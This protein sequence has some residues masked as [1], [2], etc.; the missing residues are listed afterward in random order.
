MVK[1]QAAGAAGQPVRLRL[2]PNPPLPLRQQRLF[3]SVLGCFMG[4]YAGALAI[5][6]FWPV[7]PFAGLEFAAVAAAMWVTAGRG[8]RCEVVEVTAS[9]VRVDRSRA[10]GVASIEL[11]SAW[12]QIRLV[13]GAVRWYPSR[14]LLG[15][16]GR[17]VE[18]GGFLTENERRAAAREL[19]RVLAPY[20]AWSNAALQVGRS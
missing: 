3:L 9:R 15:A 6:G 7:L 8:R 10:L 18:I 20:S 16:H 1:V 12:V 2:R 19:C 14:L 4:A 13:P 5:T 17:W 11:P